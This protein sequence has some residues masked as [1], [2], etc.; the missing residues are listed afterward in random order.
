MPNSN[1]PD[2]RK[3]NSTEEKREFIKERIVKPPM[4]KRQAAAKAL[5]L[6][7]SAAFFGSIAAVTFVITAPFAKEYLSRGDGG[8]YIGNHS[9]RRRAAAHR[10]GKHSG[11]GALYRVRFFRK[12][13]RKCGSERTG[14]AGIS[15][16]RLG[17]VLWNA[18]RTGRKKQNGTGYHYCR[19]QQTDLFNNP[20]ETEGKFSGAVIAKTRIEYLILTIADAVTGMDS[21]QVTVS[22]GQEVP[23]QIVVR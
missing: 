8:Q 18:C 6:L 2:E 5:T 19:Q 16:G 1:S 9:D 17:C 13:G 20:V 7:F 23:G 15:R 11:T 10:S 14:N 21:I 3:A 12:T 4:T 22:S